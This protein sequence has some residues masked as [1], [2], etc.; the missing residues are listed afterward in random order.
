MLNKAS[1]SSEEREV[2]RTACRNLL[3]E[4]CLQFKDR[5][6]FDDDLY[7]LMKVFFPK[8]TLSKKFHEEFSN[9]N[10]MMQKFPVLTDGLN[11]T[12]TS[13]VNSEWSEVLNHDFSNAI[14]DEYL[15]NPEAFWFKVRAHEQ[16]KNL[17]QFALNCMCVF[18]S[19]AAS[20]RIWSRLFRSKN[21]FKGRQHFQT[22]RATMLNA[23]YIQDNGGLINFEPTNDMFIRMILNVNDKIADVHDI[24]NYN[25]Y[26]GDEISED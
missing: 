18:N 4:M 25:D 19:N 16:F 15:R 9:L 22:T 11:E 10:S 24:E 3:K 1:P 13:E 17:G 14:T 7:T 21:Q 2:F 26:M 6:D 5:C 20:E 23:Q 8:N 12:K